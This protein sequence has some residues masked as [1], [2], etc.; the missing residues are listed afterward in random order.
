METIEKT[1]I[2]R[3]N[4]LSEETLENFENVSPV[5]LPENDAKEIETKGEVSF[6]GETVNVCVCGVY[7]GI[8]CPMG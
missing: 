6:T 3:L 2:E 4:E 7:S 8:T 5:E 1:K